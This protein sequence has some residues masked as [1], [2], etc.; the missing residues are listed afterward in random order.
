[1]SAVRDRVAGMLDR[2]GMPNFAAAV[3]Y[4]PLDWH[5]NDL[6]VWHAEHRDPAAGVWAVRPPCGYGRW[7]LYRPGAQPD[8]HGFD[9][10]ADVADV[11]PASGEYGG[12]SDRL[13]LADVRWWM[14]V[15]I[16]RVAGSPV[17]EMVE[18]WSE[19]YGPRRDQQEYVI[20][21]RT[22]VRS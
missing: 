6:T 14:E 5:G 10:D 3:R 17:V 19:P 20:Y 11:H 16:A 13:D 2:I 8:E 7:T 1:V 18:G 21:A 22:E 15:W 12:D 9:R 4:P